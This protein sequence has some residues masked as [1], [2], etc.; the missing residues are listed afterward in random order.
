MVEPNEMAPS[1]SALGSNVPSGQEPSK[2]HELRE[3]ARETRDQ[4]PPNSAPPDIHCG[5][6]T[7]LLKRELLGPLISDVQSPAQAAKGYLQRR[8]IHLDRRIAHLLHPSRLP[9]A[10][11]NRTLLDVGMQAKPNAVSHLMALQNGDH[12]PT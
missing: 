2:A 4:I 3:A 7:R 9:A 10:G 12:R 8:L 6:P 11:S 1:Q 5:R